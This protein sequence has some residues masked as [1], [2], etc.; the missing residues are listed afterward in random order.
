[1]AVNTEALHD[2]L[3]RLMPHVDDARIALTGGVAIGIHLRGMRGDS[4]H[5]VADD[6]DFVAE[7]VDAIR[8]TVTADFLV[9][10]FHL[11]QPGY[12]KFL[13]QLADP[14]T[15]LRLDFFTDALRAVNRAP[16]VDVA[17]VS[18]RMLEANDIL[19]HKIQLLSGASETR[20]VD[21]KHHADAK[22]LGLLCERE[23]PTV[24]ASH[25]VSTAHSRDLDATCLRCHVSRCAG[26][27]LAPKRA[28]FDVLGY[29]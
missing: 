3:R 25:L 13:V 29:V 28:I 15:R 5:A 10:H 12:P 19:D 17:G 22:R 20:P 24:S 26:F 18:L 4:R 1:M 6:V 2:C 27:P 7:G 11:P 9:S 16:V 14:A 8:Q 21:E 23:V